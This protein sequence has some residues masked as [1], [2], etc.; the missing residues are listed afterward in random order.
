MAPSTRRPSRIDPLLPSSPNR[1]ERI[2]LMTAPIRSRIDG[3]WFWSRSAKTDD[4]YTWWRAF[5]AARESTLHADP[6][7][8]ASV[9]TIRLMRC[10]LPVTSGGDA[11]SAA[12]TGASSGLDGGARPSAWMTAASAAGGCAGTAVSAASARPSSAR[13]SRVTQD[14]AA[15]AGAASATT[16]AISARPMTNARNVRLTATARASRY[17]SLLCGCGCRNRGASRRCR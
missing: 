7:G 13:Y 8:N 11:R 9:V 12:M 3:G 6:A 2:Q 10:M 5:S 1:C 17:R 4:A 14:P 16:P 15:R